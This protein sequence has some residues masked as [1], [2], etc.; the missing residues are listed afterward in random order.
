MDHAQA[1]FFAHPF[2]AW[3]AI[4]GVFLIGELVSGSGWLLWP[5]GAAAVVA[6]VSEFADLGWP[7]E[8]VL[9]AVAAIV[10]TY[11]GRRFL[12]PAPRGHGDINDLGP[13]LVGQEGTAVASFR[14]GLGRVFV[15]GKEWAAELDG[16]GELAAKSKITVLEILGGARLKVRAE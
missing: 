7:K 5:A 15:D 16:G 4:G 1:F 8:I 9:F 11:L 12:S 6:V 2:W 10:F 14:E 3:I 13:R